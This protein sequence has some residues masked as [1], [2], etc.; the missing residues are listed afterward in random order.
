MH[1]DLALYLSRKHFFTSKPSSDKFKGQAF[2]KYTW[3]K[4]L[5]YDARSTDVKVKPV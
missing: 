2:K 1:L 4:V 3:P 5:K